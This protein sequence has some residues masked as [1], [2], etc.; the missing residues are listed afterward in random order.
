MSSIKIFNCILKGRNKIIKTTVK[1]HPQK[2]SEGLHQSTIQTRL[3]EQTYSIGHMSW[4]ESE[5]QVS[6][7][8]NKKKRTEISYKC[9]YTLMRPKLTKLKWRESQSTEEY[10][11]Y[12]QHTLYGNLKYSMCP[13]L[14][15]DDCR[16]GGGPRWDAH[17]RRAGGGLT[18]VGEPVKTRQDGG[19][20]V[21]GA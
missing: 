18:T 19:T 2:R 14:L 1:Q 11:V 8:K 21:P 6:I 20:S 13:C 4:A 3:D 17:V 5:R 16:T 12:P 10:C 9:F 7:C 15:V